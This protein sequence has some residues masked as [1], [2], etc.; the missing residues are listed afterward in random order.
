M[1]LANDDPV[2]AINLDYIQIYLNN[3]AVI[4]MNQDIQLE[5]GW[6]KVRT[7]TLQSNKIM[8]ALDGHSPENSC[9]KFASINKVYNVSVHIMYLFFGCFYFCS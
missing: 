6:D 1:H 8:Y 2:L 7:L 5:R 3:K 4:L 9:V